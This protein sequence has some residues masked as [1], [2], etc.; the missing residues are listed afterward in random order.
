MFLEIREKC[1]VTFRWSG[2]CFWGVHIPNLTL[3]S[4]PCSAFVRTNHVTLSS[5]EDEQIKNKLKA[6]GFSLLQAAG[7][8]YKTLMVARGVADAYILSKDTTFKWDTCA[9]HALL[10]A[11]GGGIVEYKAALTGVI[12]ELTYNVEDETV[13]RKLERCCNVGGIIAYKNQVVL[14][15]VLNALIY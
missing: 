9:P 5:S 3:T 11:L 7:A 1:F 15:A 6:A 13:A 2:E 4:L 8:G 14:R 10:K 12:K